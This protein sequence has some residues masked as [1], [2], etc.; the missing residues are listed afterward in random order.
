MT[1]WTIHIRFSFHSLYAENEICY[2]NHEKYAKSFIYYFSLFI[3]Y[4][5]ILLKIEKRKWFV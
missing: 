2:R 1:F 5:F 3:M 4:I